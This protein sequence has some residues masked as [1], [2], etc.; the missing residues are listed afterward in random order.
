MVTSLT[1]SP[2]QHYASTLA[3]SGI[4]VQALASRPFQELLPLARVLSPQKACYI[5]YLLLGYILLHYVMM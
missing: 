3:I 1:S 5:H 2:T 4:I